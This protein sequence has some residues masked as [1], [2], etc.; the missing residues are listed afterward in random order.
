MNPETRPWGSYQI[1]HAEPGMQVKRVQINPGARLSLQKHSKRLEN[2]LVTSG[3]G[4]ATLDE[5]EIPVS[6]GVF[7]HINIG[8]K[9]RMACTGSAPLV[10]VEVQLGSYLG[11]DDII[12]FQDDFGRV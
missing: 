4:I 8:Q 12:R 7:I 5:K 9:H 11:E 3:Q 2:W 1:L 10:F 6:S